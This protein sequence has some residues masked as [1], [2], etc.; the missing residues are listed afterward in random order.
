MG[1]TLGIILIIGGI[2]VGGIIIALMTVYRNEG[3][4]TSGAATLG[5]V[6]GFLVLVLPQLGFGAFLLLR[7]RQ[8]A[9]VAESAGKQRKMLGMIKAKGQVNIADLAIEL[10][11]SRDEIQG[12]IYELVN[13]GLYSGYINWAEGTLYSSEASELRELDRCKNCNGQLELA[14][15][16]VIRCPYCGTE[17]FLP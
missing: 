6:L 12:M 1:R 16:G 17:Y 2:V 7:G 4:L 13:M 8:E 5:I 14:G 11:S 15:K 9:V 3:S 10:R